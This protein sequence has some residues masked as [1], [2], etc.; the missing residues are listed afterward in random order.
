MERGGFEP[1]NSWR[2]DLQSAAFNH[3]ATSPHCQTKKGLE[4]GGFEPPKPLVT[5]LQSAAFNHFATSPQYHA[6]GGNRTP[7]PLIT[8]QVLCQLS[9]ISLRIAWQ[10]LFQR[11]APF[12]PARNGTPYRGILDNRQDF[13]AFYFFHLHPPKKSP[14]LI[15]LSSPTNA[16]QKLPEKP[17]SL[18]MQPSHIQN[19]DSYQRIL[20]S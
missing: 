11:S 4:R 18:E 17:L 9:H 5:D 19:H 16:F 13:F 3:F 6:D 2:T 15:A 8:N 7:N 14:S 20:V 12:F 1:P 10:I